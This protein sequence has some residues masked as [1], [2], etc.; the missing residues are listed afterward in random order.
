MSVSKPQARILNSLELLDKYYERLIYINKHNFS[1]Y[2]NHLESL[3][4]RL[5]GLG[6][7]NVLERGFS[8]PTD[9][10]GNIIKSPDQIKVGETFNLKTANGSLKGKKI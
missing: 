8:I 7:D 9:S 1:H 5:V 10:R 6:P 4:K 2:Q 3:L